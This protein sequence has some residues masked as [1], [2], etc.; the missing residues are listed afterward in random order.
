MRLRPGCEDP[1]DFE[2]GG[3]ARFAMVSGLDGLTQQ[4]DAW[5]PYTG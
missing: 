2:C 1:L 4:F 5:K 3:E